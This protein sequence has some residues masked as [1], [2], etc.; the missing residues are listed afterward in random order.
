MTYWGQRACALA[1]LRPGSPCL[2]P[3]DTTMKQGEGM[4]RDPHSRPPPSAGG[5]PLHP[6]RKG[7]GEVPGILWCGI[8]AQVPRASSGCEDGDSGPKGGRAVMLPA[9]AG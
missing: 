8:D 7:P 4:F 6:H 9:T 5:F 1:C 2:C 3:G